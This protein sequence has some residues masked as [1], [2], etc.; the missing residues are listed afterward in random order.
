MISGFKRFRLRKLAHKEF[1]VPIPVPSV[2]FKALRRTTKIPKPG[3]DSTLEESLVPVA[4]S[5]NAR[6][7]E[8]QIATRVELLHYEITELCWEAIEMDFQK[9]G[10]GQ[11]YWFWSRFWRN[12]LEPGQ[13]ISSECWNF[14][15]RF[16]VLLFKS[17][18][19][20][21]PI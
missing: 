8:R 1:P 2:E 10:G 16:L 11:R 13:D 18:S 17:G 9:I 6:A 20:A 14:N 21:Q 12:W 3:K 4:W 19:S 7:L 15:R 5:N